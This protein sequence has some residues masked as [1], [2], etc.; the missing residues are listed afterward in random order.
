MA[1]AFTAGSFECRLIADGWGF[2]PAE[3]VFENAPAE[4]REAALGERLGPNGIAVPYGC[5]LAQ[6]ADRVVLVDAGIGGYEHPLGGSGG[7]LESQLGAAGVSPLDVQIV[8]ITHTH[9]DHLGGLSVDGNPRFPHARHLIS[10]T[11]WE[12]LS[13]DDD[14]I[15]YSQL[16]PLQ[17]AGLLDVVEGR[18]DIAGDIRVFPAP[19]HTPGQ[20]AV[21]IGPPGGALYMA[22][23]VIDVL[24][25]AHPDWSM[26]FDEDPELAVKTRHAL[27]EQAVAER[28][29]V[30]AAH[31]PEPGT[32]ERD[33][34]GFRFASRGAG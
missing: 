11:E 10:R 29:T 5:L 31:I 19:G 23:A 8:V 32:I 3:V 26:A 22:D 14:P 2:L 6:D 27:F 20:F 15:A 34:E 7:D 1:G 12:S 4:T 16:S 21:E 13:E 25:V 28:R 33:R 17:E 18:V 30:A 24:H 9:L